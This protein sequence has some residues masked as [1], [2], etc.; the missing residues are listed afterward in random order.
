MWETFI[1]TV[2]RLQKDSVRPGRV[3][4][5]L[6]EIRRSVRFKMTPALESVL[7]LHGLTFEDAYAAVSR[8]LKTHQR[9][10][11]RSAVVITGKGRGEDTLAMQFP[12]WLDQP[13]FNFVT[14][15][16]TQRGGGAFKVYFKKKKN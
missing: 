8:F 12:K 11:S 14:R 13:A 5:P 10:G 9:E 6:K 15:L 16:E 7:D 1:K 4:R 2:K 3:E